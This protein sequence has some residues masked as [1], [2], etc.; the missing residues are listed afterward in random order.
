ML[1]S[2]LPGTSRD[3]WFKNVLTIRRRQERE[4]SLIDLIQLVNDETLIVS[5]PI[6]STVDVEQYIDK[7]P[8]SKRTKVS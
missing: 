7:R 1:L 2:K 5:D 3:K 8:N 6:F 4:S